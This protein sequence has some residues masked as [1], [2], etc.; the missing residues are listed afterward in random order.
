MTFIR[1]R[2]LLALSVIAALTLGACSSANNEADDEKEDSLV[3]YSGRDLELVEPLIK[4]F[5]TKS[6]IKVEIRDAGSTE[7]AAQLLE[8]GAN[9]PAQVFLSQESGALGV[10]AEADLLAK[11]P[12]SITD[13]VPAEYTSHNDTWVGLTG[14]ARVI[15]YDSETLDA[16]D[17]P[18]DVFELLEPKW[19]GKFAIAPTNAS[20]QAFVTALRV[21][22]GEEA[23]EEWLKGLVANDAQVF[24]KNGAILDAVNTGEVELGLINHYYW[25]RFDGDPTTQRAKIA[26]GKPGS[27]SALVNVTGAGILTGAKDST[28]AKEFVEFLISEEAQ[29]YFLEETAEYPLALEGQSPTGVPALAD[30]GGP[31]I[32]LAKLASLE[33][34]VALLTKV[35]LV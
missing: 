2:A 33:A 15:A 27:V 24:E 1:S 21:S 22:E 11:L 18:D 14:R 9:T 34:T 25:A 32:D 10:L 13:A 29:T 17:V 20:F 30:L 28:A 12:D 26:F 8:E 4:L 35:G 23:A 5:E 31:D 6:G 3:V 19:K 16:A 7:L